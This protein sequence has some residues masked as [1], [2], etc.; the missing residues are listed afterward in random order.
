MHGYMGV[1][2]IVCILTGI[3]CECIQV[4]HLVG[5][6]TPCCP[7]NAHNT[8]HECIV[9]MG[10]QQHLKYKQVCVQ[11]TNTQLAFKCFLGFRVLYI[12]AHK[13]S[14]KCEYIHNEILSAHTNVCTHKE[15]NTSKKWI[16]K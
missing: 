11:C 2:A 10:L 5:M 6:Q 13:F 9:A 12:F 16:K 8:I 14:A 3:S 15:M 7:H 4:W 1:G